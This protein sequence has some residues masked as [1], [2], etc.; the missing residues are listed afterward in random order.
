[1]INIGSRNA[2]RKTLWRKDLEGLQSLPVRGRGLKQAYALWQSNLPWSLPVRGRGLKPDCFYL[3]NVGLK[4][5]PRAGAWI[6]TSLLSRGLRFIGL[7][8]P[9]RGRGLKLDGYMYLRNRGM[10]L[11]VRGRGLKRDS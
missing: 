6:E 5:A 8:L 3:Y 2:S 7:S 1:M 10:S 4:V 9:V 11:P